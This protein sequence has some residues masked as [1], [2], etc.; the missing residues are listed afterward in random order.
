[1]SGTGSSKKPAEPR[2]VRKRLR[3]VSLHPLDFDTAI[4]GLLGVKALKDEE[5]RINDQNEDEL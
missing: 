3:P 5:P 2:K 4:R 1:V